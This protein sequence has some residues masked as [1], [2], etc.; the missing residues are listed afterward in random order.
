MGE[1]LL[2]WRLDASHR[3]K[4]RLG[5]FFCFF[6]P[7]WTPSPISTTLR[8]FCLPAVGREGEGGEGKGESRQTAGPAVIMMTPMITPM[9]VIL[10]QVRDAPRP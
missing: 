2:I 5:L 9:V 10:G 1:L 8:L 4:T 3:P 6:G 7:Q